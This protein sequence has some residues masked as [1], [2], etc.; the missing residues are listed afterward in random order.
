MHL[1]TTYRHHYICYQWLHLTDQFCLFYIFIQRF[2]VYKYK[3][4][5]SIVLLVFIHFC[6]HLWLC[7]I[8][9]YEF[10]WFYFTHS[11]TVSKMFAIKWTLGLG[12]WLTGKESPCNVGDARSGLIPESG[13]SSGEGVGKN[14]AVFLRSMDR[15]PMDRGGTEEPGGLQSMGLQSWTWVSNYMTTTDLR[16]L[17]VIST[18]CLFNIWLQFFIVTWN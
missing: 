1:K 12:R 8:P 15:D 3:A 7:A 11:L 17:D 13:R 16:H 6:S 5:F 14:T 18:T 4:S 2:C 9:L 10:I